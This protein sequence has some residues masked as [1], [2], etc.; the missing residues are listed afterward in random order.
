M[1]AVLGCV[2]GLTPAL[3]QDNPWSGE[4]GRFVPWDGNGA[5]A[6]YGGYPPMSS[7]YGSSYSPHSA[8]PPAMV[9][10]G[11]VMNQGPYPHPRSIYEFQPQGDVRGPF[12]SSS[13]GGQRMSDA[14]QNTWFRVD[15]L[16]YELT[17]PG[18]RL[19]GSEWLNTN[20]R[21]VL[22]A[23]GNTDPLSASIIP[24]AR[25]RD[26]TVRTDIN[27]NF[28][29]APDA[30]DLGSFDFNNRNGIRLT[31][32]IPT[33][34]GT[35]EGNIWG[36]KSV[37]ESFR[38]EPVFD[39]TG[40]FLVIPAIPLTNN[41]QYVDPS[42]DV[43]APMILFDDFMHV[44]FGQEL[45]GAEINYLRRIFDYGS[46]VRFEL[47]AGARYIRFYEDMLITGNDLQTQT[48]PQILA[49][50]SN[51]VFGPSIGLRMEFEE[52]I[53]KLGAESR[54]TAAFNRHNNLVRTVDLF[55][56]N[57]TPVQFD[58]DHTDVSPIHEL[59][60]YAQIKLTHRLKLRVGYNLLT[61]FEMSRP[62]NNVV[63]DDS[64]IV[65]GP[66]LIRVDDGD[67]ETVNV[68][69]LFVSG[70]LSLF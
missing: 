12:Y 30:Q 43:S 48:S 45:Y 69:G 22:H 31:M 9:P 1:T 64:G 63:W 3:A 15:Y 41:G 7:P 26:G 6:P 4:P 21:D 34:S 65:D 62:Q 29:I 33:E 46:P 8:D 17:D 60:L 56:D 55:P 35:I 36:L 53:V 54:L 32:G 18:E 16:N 42:L 23:P 47:L 49:T 24:L 40:L 38:V 19:I 11:P 2:S 61:M 44:Q 20:A 28:L 59:S 57:R 37:D 25:D 39:Q 70:E 5:W 50:S 13:T 58:D 67:L 52:W 10:N 66:T 51:H 68:R 27:G 14:L